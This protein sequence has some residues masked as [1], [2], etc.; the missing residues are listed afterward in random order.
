MPCRECKH[1]DIIKRD[2]F[3]LNYFKCLND[4]FNRTFFIKYTDW[5]TNDE[6]VEIL[7]RRGSMEEALYLEDK[8]FECKYYEVDCV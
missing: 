3:A 6:Y 7:I 4:Q 5:K 2:E 8:D 1:I